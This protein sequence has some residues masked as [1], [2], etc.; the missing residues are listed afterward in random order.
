MLTYE[1]RDIS[2]ELPDARLRLRPWQEADIGQ[3]LEAVHESVDS[4]GRWLP[5]CHTGYGH[6]DAVEWIASCR[7]GWLVGK[8]FAFA[9]FDVDSGQLLGSAGLSQ[10]DPLH[11]RA[12]LG[13]WVRQS[14]QRRGVG[15]A[16]AR[17]VARFGFEQLGL[18]RIEI[19]VL[20]HNRASRTVAE[21]TG[22]AFEAIAR[23]R[24]WMRNSAHDAAVYGLLARDLA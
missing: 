3:L 15:A 17:A 5:W 20:P 22:A 1:T 12:N 23:N 21:K 16:A 4:V 14:R 13:Y 24:I 10:V 19:V 18:L 11:R 7:A 8:H 9:L 6:D 2:I